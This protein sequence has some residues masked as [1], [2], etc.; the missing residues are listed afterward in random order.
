MVLF[1]TS[2]RTHKSVHTSFYESPWNLAKVFDLQFKVHL[3]HLIHCG[4]LRV[5]VRG[6][7]RGGNVAVMRVRVC[8]TVSPCINV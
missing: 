3:N 8:R 5:G 7:Y 2:N 6:K 1:T 4:S